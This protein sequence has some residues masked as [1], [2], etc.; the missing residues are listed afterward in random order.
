MFY[1]IDIG[2]TNTKIAT[3]NQNLITDFQVVPTNVLVEE[4]FS[5]LRTLLET[6]T[7][8]SA[9]ISS[10]VE[11]HELQQLV[12]PY[13][14]CHLFSYLSKIPIRNCYTT[15]ETLGNDR[16]AAAI[17]AFELFPNTN[18][19]V[20]DAGSCITYDFISSRAEFMGGAIAPGIQMRFNAVHKYTNKLPLLTIQS[21]ADILGNTTDKSI[22]SGILNGILFEMQGFI[23]NYSEQ[24][25]D[26]K[27]VI[28]G[29]DVLYFENKLKSSIFAEPNLVCKGLLKV[30][31]DYNK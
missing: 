2:N 17:G 23:K 13:S 5:F 4:N 27:V 16:L 9:I 18:V 12:L 28:T 20:I 10:V 8:T 1:V 11:I 6:H 24:Y 22:L 31:T 15:P 3:C 14:N 21:N 25:N 26:L 30:L 19:L 7:Y 29:G